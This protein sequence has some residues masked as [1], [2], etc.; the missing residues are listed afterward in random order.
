MVDVRLATVGDLGAINAIY[1]HYVLHSTCT[2]QDEPTTAAERAA[3]F[4]NRAAIH[5]VTVA[6]LN[7][8]VVGWAALNRFNPRSAYRNTV[9][10]SVYVRH[11]RQRRGIGRGLLVDLL[12]R[13][14]RLGLRQIIALISADQEASVRLHASVGFVEAGRLKEVG[15]KF[16][17]WLDVV[18][19]Q[20]SVA[21]NPPAEPGASVRA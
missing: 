7:G 16:G 15:Y 11:D 9:E 12:Q 3:W 1:N 14:E 2:Y 4:E 5:P 6:V 20:Y 13:A 18:Y 19:L 21:G 17:R 8:E 10:N